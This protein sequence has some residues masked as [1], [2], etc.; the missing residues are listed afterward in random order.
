[1]LHEKARE[2]DLQFFDDNAE[3][4]QKDEQ[5]MAELNAQE[6][7]TDQTPLMAASLAGRNL[8][9][10][11][12]LSL[13]ADPHITERDGYNPPHG[14]AFQGRPEAARALIK[15]NVPMDVPHGDGFSPLH[16]TVWGGRRNHL[17]TARVLVKEGG[18]NVDRQD[19]EGFT[20]AHRALDSNWVE[21][22]KELLALGTNPNLKSHLFQ[23]T[24]LHAAVKSQDAQIVELVL[25]AGGDITI[26]NKKGQSPKELAAEMPSAKIQALMDKASAR[27]R[28]EIFGGGED[29]EEK[30]KE[31]L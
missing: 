28:S 7:G 15:H 2:G 10:D 14:V 5:A 22:L 25:E 21:M 16:R 26:K 24:L 12:L 27:R 13:G 30:K 1:M 29:A 4:F 6:E 11:K 3:V 8:I 23:D 9:V 17:L 31:E 20:A 19:A 18:A